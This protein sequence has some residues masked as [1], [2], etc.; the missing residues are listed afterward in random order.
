MNLHSVNRLI[1]R[2]SHWTVLNAELCFKVGWEV[3][4]A[5]GLRP[6]LAAALGP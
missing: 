4:E 2:G 6:V 3:G 1:D 5:P